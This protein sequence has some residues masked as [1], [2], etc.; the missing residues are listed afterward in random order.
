MAKYRIAIATSAYPGLKRGDIVDETPSAKATRA[1]VDGGVLMMVSGGSS[2][3]SR[4][5]TPEPPEEAAETAEEAPEAPEE[6]TSDDQGED[7]SPGF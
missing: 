6:P 4:S 3:S 2:S 5:E 7:A 1:R